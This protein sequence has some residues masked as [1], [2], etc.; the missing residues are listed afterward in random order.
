MATRTKEPG[1]CRRLMCE[2][3]AAGFWGPWALCR[4]HLQEAAGENV[5][6]PN[7]G[8]EMPAECEAPHRHVCEDSGGC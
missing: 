5:T 4:R 1:I 6:C 8:M 2:E 3:P 7:C